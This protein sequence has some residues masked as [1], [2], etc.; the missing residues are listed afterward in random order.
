[1]SPVYRVRIFELARCPGKHVGLRVAPLTCL[2]VEPDAEGFNDDGAEA[3][4]EKEKAERERCVLLN[5]C[6]VSA[7]F[8]P[9]GVKVALIACFPS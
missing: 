2:F 5:S 3:K 7:L 6:V 8:V 9:K 4:A 1:M